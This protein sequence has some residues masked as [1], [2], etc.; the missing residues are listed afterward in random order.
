MM[1]KSK[2]ETAKDQTEMRKDFARMESEFKQAEKNLVAVVDD[3]KF[4]LNKFMKSFAD[5]EASLQKTKVE[6]QGEVE[7][8]KF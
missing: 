6:M 4:W 8:I 3:T 7:A 2:E 5:Q 1:L